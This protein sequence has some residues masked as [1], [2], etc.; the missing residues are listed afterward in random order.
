M[1]VIFGTSA[2]IYTDIGLTFVVI[3]A[4]F[5]VLARLYIGKKRPY[6]H[7]ILNIIGVVCLYIFLSFYVLNYLLESVRTFGGTDLV[8]VAFYYVF[9]L[10]HMAGAA[11]MGILCTQQV[12]RGLK[13]FDNSQSAEWQKFPFDAE[14]RKS[15][16]SLGKLSVYL[17]VFTAFSGVVVYLMLYV[18]YT[19]VKVI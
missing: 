11:T 13:R 10:I 12:V 16:R 9:L 14:Y 8:T 15:H 3:S 1:S 6:I 5:G 4:I 17:W 7:M 2:S 18:F 19:P